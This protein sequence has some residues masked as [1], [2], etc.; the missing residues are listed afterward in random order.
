MSVG[1]TKPQRLHSP[2]YTYGK[3]RLRGWL[4]P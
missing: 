1:S 4:A 2:G 3:I